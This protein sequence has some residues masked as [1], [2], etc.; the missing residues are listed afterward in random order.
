MKLLQT[1]G[2]LVSLSYYIIRKTIGKLI[3]LIWVKEV[4]GLQNIPRRGASLIALNHQS[5]FDF[6]TIASISPRNIHFLSAEKFFKHPLWFILMTFTGQVKVLRTTHDK[7]HTHKQVAILLKKGK[8]VGI[9]PEGTRSHLKDEM[10]KAFSGVGRYALEHR[11]PII[12][13][14]IKGAEDIIAKHESKVKFKKVVELHIGAP[15]SFEEYHGRHNEKEICMYVTEKAIK[16]IEKLSGKK[17][18]H[19]EHEHND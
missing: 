11:V 4:S 10:L 12:P 8:L 17:Y 19:Y 18:P 3:K 15:L 9:F 6:L 1:H 13:V 16:Q 7:E 5:F 2:R 14:G